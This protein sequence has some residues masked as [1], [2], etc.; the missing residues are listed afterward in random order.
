VFRN[1]RGAG[2]LEIDLVASVMRSKLSERSSFQTCWPR[3]TAILPK[4]RNRWF[5]GISAAKSPAVNEIPRRPP[6]KATV[7]SRSLRLRL[8]V[9]TIDFRRPSDA[10]YLWISSEQSYNDWIPRVQFCPD[11]EPRI[12]DDNYNSAGI[13]GWQRF[14]PNLVSHTSTDD[15]GQRSNELVIYM[16][17]SIGIFSPHALTK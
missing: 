5:Q 4:G 8:I 11:S 14:L 12:P 15:F 9:E 3:S 13:V 7:E 16:T 17:V 6:Q 2:S 10:I 1:G